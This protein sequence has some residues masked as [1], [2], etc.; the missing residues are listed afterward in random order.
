MRK[1]L[2]CVILFTWTKYVF[3]W[4]FEPHRI[5][6][7]HAVLLLPT[8]LFDFFKKHI[9][10]ISSHSTDPDQRRY[11]DSNE[12]PKHYIDIE[13]FI[14]IDSI[15]IFYN[16]ANS[17]WGEDLLNNHGSVPW[18]VYFTIHKLKTAFIQQNAELILK[19][20]AELG[21]YVADLH[22]PL[23]TTKNYNGQLT[24]QYG[25]HKLWETEV[26]ELYREYP[27]LPN[28]INYLENPMDS[29][30][31]WMWESHNQ[32]NNV[33]ECEFNCRKNEEFI[34]TKS[35]L[36]DQKG[37]M[38]VKNTVNFIKEYENCLRLKVYKRM[39]ESIQRVASC[40]YTSWILAGQPTLPNSQD[41]SDLPIRHIN[42]NINLHEHGSC[43]H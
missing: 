38:S 31:K 14:G 4:G 22:V 36:Q 28:E 20:S 42:E 12:A 16:A 24:N 15:P 10:Y 25:I 41:I 37:L 1:W 43:H 26:A 32:V 3:S 6:N 27:F 30:W 18:T 35:Y 9:E 2:L 40:I 34:I 11:I 29:I 39:E 17:K 19:H 33:M 13:F 8:P 5:I 7:K 21:H 23:H